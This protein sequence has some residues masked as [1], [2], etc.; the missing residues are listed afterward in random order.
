MIVVSVF[1]Y[2]RSKSFSINW[3]FIYL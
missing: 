2:F 3:F 1:F